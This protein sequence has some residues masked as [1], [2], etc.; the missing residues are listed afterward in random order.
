M[1]LR[2]VDLSQ[3]ERTLEL[4]ASIEKIATKRAKSMLIISKV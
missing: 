1:L 2:K 3:N 4:K